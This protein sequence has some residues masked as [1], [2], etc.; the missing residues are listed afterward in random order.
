VEK[1]LGIDFAADPLDFSKMKTV[2][3]RGTSLAVLRLTFVGEL[4]YEL[5]VPKEVAEECY[6]AVRREAEE[7]QKTDSFPVEDAGY[8]CIDSLSAEKGFRHWHADLSNAD[9]PAEAGIGFVALARLKAGETF[10]GS[11][12]LSKQRVDGLSRK[13]VCLSVPKEA[14]PM[15]GG[16]T[17]WKDGECVGYVKS[18]AFGHTVNR[19]ISYGYVKAPEGVKI[20]NKWLSEGS[21]QMGDKGKLI[22]AQLH[23]TALVDPKSERVKGNY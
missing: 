9:T 16:E 5:H 13:L 19:T 21:Y 18:T 4:G 22:D 12:A 23:L 20:T 6:L 10:L 15:H 14:G 2:D 11:E 7:L 3:F 1:A 8:M 17:I